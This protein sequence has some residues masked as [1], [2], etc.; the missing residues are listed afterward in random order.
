MII[1]R[2]RLYNFGVYAGDNEFLFTNNKP[3]VLIGGMNGRGKTTFLEAVL[4]ALYG[5]NS[6]AYTESKKRSYAQYLKSFVNKNA[7]DKTCIVELEFEIN[8]G[9]KENYIVKRAWNSIDKKTNESIFVCKDG[10]A[11]EFLTQNWSMF[12]ENILPSALSS[13]FFFDGEKIA[14]MAVDSSNNQLKNAIRSMLGITVLDVLENDILRNIKKINKKDINDKSSEVVQELRDEKNQAVKEL[15]EID[16]EI[17]KLAHVLVEDNDKLESLHQLYNAKGGDA[18]EKKQ[19]TMKR[20]AALKSELLSEENLLREIASNELPLVLVSDLLNNIKLQ[21]IDEHND[22]VMREA[23]LQLDDILDEFANEYQGDTKASF[24]FIKY[25]KKR[26]QNAQDAPVYSLSDQALFQAN[27]LVEGLLD[28]SKIEAKRILVEK[29][30]KQKQIGELD[31]YLSLDINEKGLQEVYK[32]IK[33]AEGKLIRD[34]VKMSALEQKRSA[35]NSKVMT[36]TSEFNKYVEAYLATAESRDSAERTIKYSNMALSILDRYQVEL[37]KRKTDILAET[38]TSCYKK[39]ANKKNLIN[40]IVMEADSLA[41]KYLS[42]EGKEVTQDSL[43]AG[44]QQ[45]MVISI[46][47]A[48]AICSKKKLPVIIDTPLSRLDSLHRTALI[49][50]YFPNA[51]EQTIILSTDSEIDSTYYG[52]MKE[53]VGDEFTLKYDEKTKS[54]SIER[55]YLIGA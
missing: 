20:R 8:N 39:L 3:I 54:T 35:A 18:V 53:N 45:L 43:S 19:E 26:Q 16:V 42:E 22:A 37:Q 50:T 46:L 9:L 4:L 30:K 38:I 48:L 52:L 41:I 10:V 28:S 36:T 21:A 49:N 24:D 2:L 25:V 55:G 15:E 29:K 7:E 6:V 34:Q 47:W 11:N 32:S 23:V 13:F 40:K 31:S 14:E 17:E 51:G 27:N 33:K 44:E 1:R 12:V 5:S